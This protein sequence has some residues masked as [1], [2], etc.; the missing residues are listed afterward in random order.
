[1]LVGEALGLDRL[2]LYLNLDRPLDPTERE[3]ARGLVMR[4]GR[5]EP[6]AHI[7]GRREFYGH[8]F[9]VTSDTLVPRP[10]TE[11]LVDSALEF[12]AAQDEA[13]RP[14]LTLEED[15]AD[16]GDDQLLAP[17]ARS[18][19][20]I[21]PL[22]RRILEVGLGS[23]C[24][25]IS[26]ALARQGLEVVATELSPAAA[27]VARRNAARLSVA[28]RLT[29][30]VQQ[31]LRGLEAGGLFDGLVSNPPYVPE[32]DRDQLS[33]D[34]RDWEPATALFAG[35]DGL[36]CVRWLLDEARNLLRPGAFA[37][38]EIGYD[39]SA[40]VTDLAQGLG[41]TVGGFRRDY[42][43]HERIALLQWGGI[44]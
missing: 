44:R 25:A 26:L 16:S 12:L 5:L 43:G 15:G 11:F 9:E 34:V 24:V 4:R 10:E 20:P 27:E 33:P 36:D 6:V 1:L 7:L 23:G 30:Q 3:R 32:R 41:W 18:A 40:L 21:P 39:Q 13:D 42:A 22:P 28:D 31:D 2:G 37:A 8:E 29:I 14:P 35:P 38:L 19:A 17:G